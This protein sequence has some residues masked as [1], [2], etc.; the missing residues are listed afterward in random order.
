MS[1]SGY[2]SVGNLPTGRGIQTAWHSSAGANSEDPSWKKTKYAHNGAPPAPAPHNHVEYTQVHHQQVPQSQLPQMHQQHQ[3]KGQ[4]HPPQSSSALTGRLGFQ[5]RGNGA[6]A[7]TSVKNTPNQAPSGQQLNNNV[8]LPVG[9]GVRVPGALQVNQVAAPPATSG[10]IQHNQ[11]GKGG[12]TLSSLAVSNAPGQWGGANG[13]NPGSNGQLVSGYGVDLSNLGD[14]NNSSDSAMA[15][16]R[17]RNREHAK[18]SRVRKK[19]MLESLQEDVRNL[20]RENTELRMILQDKLPH[21]AQNVFDECCVSS[22]LFSDGSAPIEGVSKTDSETLMKADFNLIESLATSQQNFVLSDPRLPDN[23]IV[24]A[25]AGFYELTGYTREQVLGRNCRF[26]QG[27]GTDPKHIE[28][29]RNAVSNGNDFSVCILNYKADGTP[30]W[31]QL[32]VAAL[33]DNDNCIVNYVSTL[34]I[35]Y[36]CICFTSQLN[37]YFFFTQRL[38]YNVVLL[39]NRSLRYWKIKLIQYYLWRLRNKKTQFSKGNCIR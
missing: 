11:W 7:P 15:E 31:N 24:Y 14:P 21:L 20:Q 18:R 36:N 25:S 13:M 1:T 30:F 19:F 39:P 9:V 4:I 16:R 33:R 10:G 12:I 37:S 32:F 35:F 38:V 6:P 23:P 26:L 8:T 5:M 27:P 22:K 28:H 3:I 2:N 34:S 17:Q 29:I